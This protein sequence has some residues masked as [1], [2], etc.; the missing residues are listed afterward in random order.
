MYFDFYRL[1]SLPF[2]ITADP[3]FFFASSAHK[4]ALSLLL[5]GIKEKRGLMLV[6]GEVGT[7]KTT[8]C[9]ALLEKL[10]ALI[11]SSLILNPYF[12]DIQLLQAILEDFGLRIEKKNRLEMIKKLNS[13]LLQVNASGGTAVLIIDEAQNLS[14]RQLEQIRLLSNLETSREKLL[15]IIL[16]GQPELIN[17]LKDFPLRQIYQRILIK[18][19]LSPLKE[20]EVLPYIQHRLKLAGGLDIEVLPEASKIIYEFS[21]GIP[22]LINMLCERALFYGFVKEK[23]V[24]DASVF[25]ACIEELR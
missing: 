14:A 18:Y 4:E 25:G 13:F 21:Q 1:K 15:Q 22:R 10:P 12:S 24:F 20:E 6:S 16:V 23:K 3:S 9:K 7:G 2:N 19:C 5:F 11:K 8:L 17:K